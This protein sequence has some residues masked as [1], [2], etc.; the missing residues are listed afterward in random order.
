[1]ISDDNTWKNLPYLF[2]VGQKGS[3]EMYELFLYC[4][5][6][7]GEMLLNEKKPL[8]YNVRCYENYDMLDQSMIDSCFANHKLFVQKYFNFS[9]GE[10]PCIGRNTGFVKYRKIYICVVYY[11]RPYAVV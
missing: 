3:I 7:F 1:M 8:N 6:H 10:E 5:F 11:F 9:L 2:D 4:I